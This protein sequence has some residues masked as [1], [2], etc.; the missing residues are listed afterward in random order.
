MDFLKINF[1]VYLSYWLRLLLTVCGDIVSNPGPGSDR[2]VRVLYSNICGL[3]ANLD[4]L[5]VTGS[6]YDVFV[7]AESKVPDR[8]H[9]SELRIHPWL[10]LS[11][12]E[13]EELHTW[14]P[15]FGSLC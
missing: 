3:H 2:R 4:K 1:F 12:T 15:G 14:C 11:P 6:D 7:C 8:R 5:A 9:P 13:T 10:C